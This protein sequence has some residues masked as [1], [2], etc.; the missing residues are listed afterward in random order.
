MRQIIKL[1]L[2][3]MEV[4]FNQPPEIL[5]TYT[6]DEL[7][8][9][10]IIKN[11]FSKTITVEGTKQNN[12][13]FGQFWNL[14]R[15][16][17]YGSYTGPDFNSSKKT[18]FQLFVN[19]D[20]YESGYAK[21]IEVRKTHNGIEYDIELFG[22]LGQFFSKLSANES[23][24]NKLKLSDLDYMGTDNPD[25]EFNFN[26]NK[27]LVKSCWDNIDAETGLSHYIQFIPAYNGYP[28]KNFSADKV[29]CNV[30]NGPLYS[31]ADG[32]GDLLPE[33]STAYTYT[34]YGNSY[35]GGALPEKLTEWEI[36]DLRSFNQRPCIR[37]M[38]IVK[39]CERYMAK[40][41]NGGWEIEYDSDFFNSTNPY[42][43]KS[44]VTLPLLSEIEYVGEEQDTGYTPT[45][46]VAKKSNEEFEITGLDNN[47]ND[48]ALSV[49]LSL[50]NNA[51]YSAYTDL[52]V[53]QYV[54][55][56]RIFNVGQKY[57]DGAIV[58]QMEAFDATGNKICSSDWNYLTNN[59]GGSTVKL[60]NW[61]LLGNSNIIKNAGNF[62][63]KNGAYYWCDESG[64]IADIMF[65]LSIQGRKFS[66]IK[67]NIK[68]LAN[69]NINSGVNNGVLYSDNNI[70]RIQD[71]NSS[72]VKR[73]SSASSIQTPEVAYVGSTISD[74]VGSLSNKLFTKQ[75]LLNTS[76][77]PAEYLIGF[78][79]LF[80]LHF[81]KDV[82][83]NKIKIMTRDNFYK[84]EIVSLDK[85]IDRSKQ[86]TINPTSFDTQ[87]LDFKLQ[88]NNSKFADEYKATTD[89]DYGVKRIN[90][91]YDFND[92]VKDLLANNVYKGAVEC[93]EKSKYYSIVFGTDNGIQPW[94][95]DGFKY[96]LYDRNDSDN[97]IEV[98]L[99]QTSYNVDGISQY[100]KFYDL[101]PKLQF[102]SDD[103]KSI[104]GSNV[105]VFF[106][107]TRN[108][109]SP[110]ST[111][112]NYWLTDDI[113]A[114]DY[115][116]GGSCWLYTNSESD[117]NGEQIAIKVRQLPVFGRYLANESNTNIQYSFDFGQPRM[118]YVPYYQTNEESTIYNNFWKTY[119]EDLYDVNTK[120]LDCYV[121]LEDKPN[122]EWLRKFYWFDNSIWR[123]NKIQ[124]WNISSFETTKMQFIK[125][126]DIS[127]YS[128]EGASVSTGFTITANPSTLPYSGGLI[129]FTVT[130]PVGFCWVGSDMWDYYFGDIP[131]G[132]GNKI[133]TYSL[134]ENTTGRTFNLGLIG[135]QDQRTG[136]QIV[137]EPILF[138]VAIIGDY[139]NKNLP[140]DGDTN[141]FLV[142][143]DLPWTV[144]VT[145]SFVTLSPSSG[146]GSNIGEIVLATWQP[147]TQYGYRYCTFTFT[148]SIG[149]QIVKSLAQDGI[150]TE[151]LH[152]PYEGGTKTVYARSNFSVLTQP[153]WITAV[154]NGDGT[155]RIVAD[156]NTG[157]YRS[158]TVA[159][160]NGKNS[161][162]IY[163]E[164]DEYMA[165][166]GTTGNT[167]SLTVN[168]FAQYSH[169][170]VPQT[171]ATL[172][173]NVK[174]TS[175]WVV[176]SNETYCIPQ[177]V[178]GTGDTVYGETVE[179][180]WLASNILGIRS[181]NLTF[182]N[183]EGGEV[184]L[185]KEQDG[186]AYITEHYQSAGEVKQ[187][188]FESGATIEVKPDWITVN[189]IGNNTYEFIAPVNEGYERSGNVVLQKTSTLTIYNI[190]EASD[191]AGTQTQFQITP[192]SL[193]W[194]PSGGMQYLQ[195]INN[196]G[197]NWR[198]VDH[199]QWV[200][201]SMGQGSSSAIIGVTAAQNESSSART[202]NLVFYNATEGE[203]YIV[204]CSQTSTE[205]VGERVITINPNPLNVAST[206]GTYQ[207]TITYTNRNG[208]FLIPGEVSGVT[209]GN[210][211]FTG[212]TANVTVS[213]PE[214]GEFSGKTYSVVFNGD[215]ISATLTINQDAA[216]AYLTVTPSEITLGNTGGTAQITIITNDTWTIS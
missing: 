153:D 109:I 52:Y 148:N 215:G 6:Q 147:S 178:S 71:Y 111:E 136:V 210:V 177:R 68:W 9:P 125:V 102:H 55:Y 107:G 186:K 110:N 172:L 43:Q 200:T 89:F 174:S 23:T 83:E 88:L 84:N 135:P 100:Q 206:G 80:N 21:L 116:N 60:Y 81:L 58:M 171:G 163:V 112:L 40:P 45:I 144:T 159:M 101:T 87:W 146:S 162:I 65:N 170:N 82:Y 14:E 152:Y 201:Y 7:T 75:L 59:R 37:M 168:Q 51:A 134:D 36:G 77:S 130:A 190:Q 15:I 27:N 79:K 42:W 67:L 35:V 150:L 117:A 191:D 46:Q 133:F 182:T 123:I 78:C 142:K 66:K 22:G 167:S 211:Q 91:G 127:N 199:P 13:I 74:S 119:I 20:I 145:Q 108:C 105:L 39:A 209:V 194:E 97:T 94:M 70:V 214:N 154:N 4:E 203:N 26:I 57:Y 192:M 207:V 181:A 183:T 120:V 126:Q 184:I 138:D 93:V 113:P 49:R 114:M 212:D 62:K 95:L 132:C 115:L 63:K 106:N 69:E 202:G 205:D 3:D 173:Y 129:T 31:K 180:L 90:T 25:T 53:S 11:S 54:Q 198:I 193:Y 18:P 48:L 2:G 124:D 1:Y 164:Q 141:E 41:E 118:L 73:Y 139:V 103:N 185:S 56:T 12:N 195:I 92:K 85:Y 187:I 196:K 121:R 137:Q 86:I 19:G 176:S 122:P 10:T 98:A 64:D 29:I 38:E 16:Q 213:V 76:N 28:T 50:P 72:D 17:S 34:A 128:S 166:S 204:V 33:S 158:G 131:S 208:D 155:W 169:S 104:D 156:Y 32:D 188:V 44:Y 143:S 157:A 8:N 197:E 99:E 175:P 161:L 165:D 179:V 24:G 61:D 96:N 160:A 216:T 30:A 140:K 5:Y 189:Y 151:T 47:F 149:M